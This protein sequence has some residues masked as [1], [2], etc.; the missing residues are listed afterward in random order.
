MSEINIAGNVK[1][2]SLSA[3]EITIMQTNTQKFLDYCSSLHGSARLI[4]G[5]TN[6]PNTSRLG[7]LSILETGDFNMV[8]YNCSDDEIA[9]FKKFEKFET[10]NLA[11]DI[12]IVFEVK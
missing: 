7:V 4:Q 12:K 8:F 6:V 3:K 10:N 2:L 1:V 9:Q 5:E 11:N